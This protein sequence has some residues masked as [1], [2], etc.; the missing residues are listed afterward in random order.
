M[1]EIQSFRALRWGIN[2]VNSVQIPIE[3]EFQNLVSTLKKSLDII[4]VDIFVID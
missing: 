3:R 1:P 2:I 4:S